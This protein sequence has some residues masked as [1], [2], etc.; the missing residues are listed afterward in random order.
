LRQPQPPPWDTPAFRNAYLPSQHGETNRIATND[1]VRSIMSAFNGS[2]AR[3]THNP[4]PY[5]SLLAVPLFPSYDDTER[6]VNFITLF[7]HGWAHDTMAQVM[8]FNTNYVRYILEPMRI[9]FAQSPSGREW[10]AGFYSVDRAMDINIMFIA[11]FPN[12]LVGAAP[13]VSPAVETSLHEVGRAFGLNDSLTVLFT[14]IFTAQRRDITRADIRSNYIGDYNSSFDRVLLGMTS[15]ETFWRAAFTSNEAYG[16]LWDTY[17]YDI[18]SFE[19]LML[20]RGAIMHIGHRALRQDFTLINAFNQ[21]HGTTHSIVTLDALGP[22]FLNAFNANTPPEEREAQL[23]RIVPVLHDLAAFAQARRLPPYISVRNH[24]IY[25]NMLEI[26][27]VRMGLTF[28]YTIA[29]L[30]LYAVL[31]VKSKQAL[32]I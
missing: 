10:F 13:R 2:W 12:P 29:F 8:P 26:N 11:L 7:T 21:R 20:A 3:R 9:H 28:I 24:T 18:I 32:T 1:Q 25:G 15:Q 19:A 23:A 30:I 14:E 16:A 31:R 27:A 17:L 4:F 5:S 6:Q 22:G